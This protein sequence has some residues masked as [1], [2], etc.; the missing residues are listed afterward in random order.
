MYIKEDLIYIIEQ[1]H[2]NIKRSEFT[3]KQIFIYENKESE[4][5]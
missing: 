1:S 2:D 4:K 3:I 5:I